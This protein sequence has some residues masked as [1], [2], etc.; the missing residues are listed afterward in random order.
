MTIANEQQ[1][2]ALGELRDKQAIAQTLASHARGIDRADAEMLAAVYHPDAGADYGFFNGPAAQMVDTLVEM[3]RQAPVTLHRPANLWIRTRGDV[4]VSE[5]YVIAYMAA[6]SGDSATQSLIGGRYLDR[7]EFRDGAWRI[8]HRTYVL[9]WNINRPSTASLV[10]ATLA[11]GRFVP[12]GAHGAR[13]PGNLHLAIH[14]ADFATAT[15]QGN[16]MTNRSITDSDID[17]MLSRQTLQELLTAYC[18][19]VD[20]GDSDLL[21]SIFHDDATVI[22]GVFNGAAQEFAREIVRSVDETS[23]RVFHSINNVWL[24]VAGDRAVGECYAL[25]VQTVNGPDGLLDILVGG[26]Y[27]DRFERRDG[28]WK[29]AQH[30]FVL[31]W[32]MTQPCTAVMDEGMFGDMI[33]G[34]RGAADPVHEFWSALS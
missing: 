34:T 16:T 10:E 3:Q 18:R 32:N 6:G 1:R 25:A 31:D 20:R 12:M 23:V 24:E 11:G 22:T 17:A 33:H 26:R 19:G 30:T 14:S 9:D 5:S 2:V 13:D 27:L 7:H 28:V 29:I 21:A 8:G 15:S 4:A